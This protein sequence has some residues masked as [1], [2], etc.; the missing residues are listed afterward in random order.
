MARRIRQAATAEQ[1]RDSPEAQDPYVAPAGHYDEFLAAP[2]IPRR[3]WRKL[4]ATMSRLGAERFGRRWQQALQLIQANG[5]SY[6]VYGDPQGS[7][8]PWPLD[9]IPLVIPA[10]E[11]NSIE[12]AVAQRAHV[13]NAVL[14]DF[15]GEQQLLKQ[16]GFPPDLV[17]RNP[18]FFRPFHRLPAPGGSEGSGP[19]LIHYAADLARSPDG[20]W[21]VI[22]D[23]AQAPSGPGY[24]LENRLVSAQMLP[25]AFQA[26]RVRR[27]A[28]YFQ[29]YREGLLSLA[30]TGRDQ[31][32]VVLLTPGPFNETYF[33]HAYLAKYLGFPLVEGGDLSVRDNRVYLKTLSGLS[34]VDVIL[35]RQD[36][37]FCDPLEL[38]G[39]SLLGV[40]GLVGA[41]R[42]GEVAV[43][44]GLGSG[45]LESPAN[46][47]F[48]PAY[49]RE[50]TGGGLALPSLAT[51]WCGQD[52]ARRYVL[53]NLKHLVIK[54]AFPRIGQ[55]PVFGAAL[56][57]DERAKLAL[58]IERRPED[59]VGQETMALSSAPAWNGHGVEARHVV[60]RVFAAWSGSNY[61][62]M[63]GGLTRVAGSGDSLVVNMQRGGGSKDTWILSDH[64]EEPIPLMPSTPQKVNTSRG[65]DLPSR[66]ADNL[67]WLGRYM[68][69]VETDARLARALMPAL[70]GECDLGGA[71][72]VE[73]AV[74]L[75]AAY[76]HL[77]KELGDTH[78]LEQRRWLEK[79]LAAMLFEG[80]RPG[81][82]LWTAKQISRL[83]WQLRE[84]LST[85]TSRLLG[86]LEKEFQRNRKPPSG[87]LMAEMPELDHAVQTLSAF[88]GM[89]MEN[90]TRGY[91]WRFL[92]I[93]RRLERASQTASLL[94][95]G[96]AAGPAGPYLETLL[97]V[98]DSTMTYRSRYYTAMQTDLVLDL[99]LN[100]EANPRSI[101]F[102][103]ETL[104]GHWKRL[105]EREARERYP[106]DARTIWELLTS[107][108]M[109]P[110]EQLSED[111]PEAREE[112]N[113]LLTGIEDKLTVLSDTLAVKYLSHAAL[114]GRL[115]AV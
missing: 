14:N 75:M 18:A 73:A 65:A 13:L 2:G 47:A 25:E 12:S 34:R 81:G 39:D 31:P 87:R 58:A 72:A 107:V 7:G 95:H 100:D 19:R 8:R 103:L 80:N 106:V 4:T 98:A 15:L 66:V 114:A 77:P 35:R 51:W 53:N 113:E 69:R 17:F 93:G 88:N 85:D 105:P 55:S 22:A 62:V 74:Q 104:A 78:P 61:E 68:E 20:R 52:E 10:E 43:A 36:D 16:S 84:R 1:R 42:A 111:S 90:M 76:G 92:D 5:I 24:A 46:M 59:Y 109:A 102:Q 37:T 3:H 44:N 108:R 48:L 29:S 9:P 97:Q 27:L 99:L 23:R 67:Y 49:C 82:L 70:S 57:A 32:R 30:R 45:M 6:N 50:L 41:I 38:R 33:E 64:D 79:A 115:G 11:W 101:A 26:A 112:L 40:P 96:I 91:S 21:W 60:L 54:P 89:A 83:G 94:R 86:R 63:P 71:I 28:R 56:S 110:V